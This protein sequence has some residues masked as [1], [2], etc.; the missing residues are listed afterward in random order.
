M[1][2][3]GEGCQQNKGAAIDNTM[4]RSGTPHS[5]IFAMTVIAPPSLAADRDAPVSVTIKRL[6]TYQLTTNKESAWQANSSNIFLT[7][8]SRP[9]S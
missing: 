2:S 3:C 8:V 5:S 6:Y 7:P 4:K 9:M 1:P